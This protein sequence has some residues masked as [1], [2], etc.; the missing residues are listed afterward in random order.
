MQL[1]DDQQTHPKRFGQEGYNES[2]N[3]KNGPKKRGGISQRLRA[4]Q[5]WLRLSQEGQNLLGGNGAWQKNGNKR[6]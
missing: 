1:F 5:G 3:T 2:P 6:S 4:G